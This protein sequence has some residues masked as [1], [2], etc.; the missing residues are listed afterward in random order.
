MGPGGEITERVTVTVLKPTPTAQATFG[1]RRIDGSTVDWGGTP[2][3]ELEEY[4][5]QMPEPAP[6]SGDLSASFAVAWDQNYLYV[7]IEVTDDDY[8]VVGGEYIHQ[9]DGV[10]ILLDGLNDRAERMGYDDHQI[11]VQ[12]NGEVQT[13]DG[14]GGEI[15]A[16]GFRTPDGYLLEV[17][18]PWAYVRGAPPQEGRS[19]GFTIVVTDRDEGS[20][21]SQLFWV[22]SPRHWISTVG[23]GNL[24]LGNDHPLVVAGTAETVE[25]PV[26]DAPF[27]FRLVDGNGGDWI[28]V[29]REKIEQFHP[30]FSQPSP[31]RSDLNAQFCAAWDKR[32]FYVFVWVK[33]D[34][35]EIEDSEKIYRNDGIEILID[36]L[37]DGGDFGRDDH[38]IFIRADGKVQAKGAAPGDIVAA[39][40]RTQDGYAIEAAVSWK[41]VGGQPPQEGRIY[42]FGVVINDRDNG[43]RETQAFWRFS[44]KHWRS[45][46]GWGKMRLGSPPAPSQAPSPIQLRIRW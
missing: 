43:K 20:R 45:T 13:S 1:K 26:V 16:A 46:S 9:R 44:R 39:A 22:Y 11:F 31:S 27:G 40:V 37:N 34:S 32:Y 38:Q 6:E 2:L 25:V 18:V 23:Y 21:Q 42:G 41:Y 10:E 4:N 36:G 30:D 35:Y 17:A 5:P 24:L 19:Y 28:G 8:Q 29:K 7:L 3:L 15:E 33:D 14:E 12:A